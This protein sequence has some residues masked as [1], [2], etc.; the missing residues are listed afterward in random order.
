MTYRTLVSTFDL[1]IEFGL[2]WHGSSGDDV[3]TPG[4]RDGAIWGLRGDDLFIA[5][6]GQNAYNGGEGVDTVHIGGGNA[7]VRLTGDGEGFL[8]GGLASGDTFTSIEAWS[9]DGANNRFLGDSSSNMLSL[10][11]T[12]SFIHMG[13]GHDRVTVDGTGHWV[14]GGDGND[15]VSVVDWRDIS[16]LRLDGDAGGDVLDFSQRAPVPFNGQTKGVHIDIEAGT[17]GDHGWKAVSTMTGF[18]GFFGTEADDTFDFG[19][20]SSDS[21]LFVFNGGGGADRYIIS[22][23]AGADLFIDLEHGVDTLVLEQFEEIGIDASFDGSGNFT[24]ELH[25]GDYNEIVRHLR[26]GVNDENL[27]TIHLNSYE[28]D[29]AR[30]I[31]DY[32]KALETDIDGQFYMFS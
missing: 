29:G 5:G 18:E 1:Q 31:D 12:N 4:D 24:A 16:G 20:G 13:A 21:D 3:F 6:S 28:V 7:T 30:T 11:G 8:S 26:S 27:T 23:A 9:L 2:W 14:R 15:V 25:L 17:F 32:L 19:E 10:D 22:G